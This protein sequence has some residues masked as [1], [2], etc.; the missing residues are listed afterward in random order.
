MNEENVFAPC[1]GISIEY[2]NGTL[3]VTVTASVSYAGS[4]AGCGMN[5]NLKRTSAVPPST[6]A[7]VNVRVAPSEKDNGYIS[8]LVLAQP[9]QDSAPVGYVKIPPASL[10]VLPN[11]PS[12]KTAGPTADPESVPVSVPGSVPV[13]SPVSDVESVPDNAE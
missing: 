11:A 7:A 8:S 1:D 6:T 3:P 10:I 5:S 13:S 2:S 4:T 12:S 9:P